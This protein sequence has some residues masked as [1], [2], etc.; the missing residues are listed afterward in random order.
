MI[1]SDA[2]FKE[3]KITFELNQEEANKDELIK[4]LVSSYK[5]F[6]KKLKR[7]EKE[8][9]SLKNEITEIKNILQKNN[10]EEPFKKL[11]DFPSK[12]LVNKKEIDL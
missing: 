10:E 2:F 9:E 7:L 1:Y 3:N 6:E 8:N 11:M 12:I 4:Y 5:N